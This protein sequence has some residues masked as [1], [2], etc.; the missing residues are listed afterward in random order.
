MDESRWV[1]RLLTAA[2]DGR[3]LDCAGAEIPAADVR[4]A[5]LATE[6]ALRLSRARITGRLDLRTC[7]IAVP[8]RFASCD[9][10]G[11]VDVEGAK[12][13]ELVITGEAARPAVLPGL[14]AS[15]TRIDRDLNLSGMVLQSCLR[16]ADADIGGSLIATG[17]RIEPQHGRAV[18]AGRL[19]VAGD[20]RLTE[21]FRATGELRMPAVHVGGSAEIIG[22]GR[23]CR[24]D[25]RIDMSHA[26]IRG[27]LLIR[28]ADLT[29]T[30]PAGD[31]DR[32]VLLAPRLTVHGTLRVDGDTVIRGGILLPGAQLDGGVKLTGALWNPG[33]TAL[34][35]NQA[36]L[37]AF[38]DARGLSVEG[39]VRLTGA[40]IDGLLCL[41]GVTLAKPRRDK[42]VSAVNLTVTGDAQLRGLTAV[43]GSLAFRG[44]SITGVFDAQDAYLS[45]PGGPTVSLHMAQVTGNVRLCG[46]FH[47]IG[48][49]VLIRAVIGGR[50]RADGATLT[51][52]GDPGARASAVDAHS[53]VIR[54][55]LNLGWQVTAGAVNLTGAGTSYLADRPGQDWPADSYVSGFTY[56]RFEAV[57]WHSEAVWDADARITWLSRM[58]RYD[59]RAWE[60]LAAVLRAAGD[61]DGAETVLI[62]QRRQGRR[63]RTGPRRL[64]DA[65]QDIT[66]RYGFRPQRALYLLVA[67]IAAVTAGLS[68]P[69]VQAQLRAT[70][71]NALVFTPAGAQPLPG[72]HQPPG[73]CGNGKVRCL[74]PVFYAVDTV[75]P[76]IDLH[77]RSTWYPVAERNGVLLEWLL[78]LCTILGW[79]ASTVFA[80]SFT[81]LGRAT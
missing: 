62:A 34:D 12:L 64:F 33:D 42:C 63:L 37:G 59:P 65:L 28:G 77:Q 81:R 31:D 36:V 2:R 10:T 76:L 6:S 51:W 43:G 27:A 80:V 50:L 21:G 7:T 48:R 67:L 70:D 5:L 14:L 26:T 9:F 53:A 46:R 75:I 56:E 60:Q 15:G 74:S 52:K 68:L 79:L 41:D 1:S 22:T 71:Q 39:T 18:D 45:N 58:T 66:V 55:G 61:V 20:I 3:G 35:L 4:A 29:A 40:R 44:A 69:Q 19:R 73:E 11:P 23:R 30:P 32:A 8:V 25:G 47:S 78:N 72:E 49:V 16:L 17:T 24:L 57:D 38:L 54:G 13:H